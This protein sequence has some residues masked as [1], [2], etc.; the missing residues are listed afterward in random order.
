MKKVFFKNFIFITLLFAVFTVKISAQ[1]VVD[2]IVAT[3]SDGVRTQVITY[4]DLMWQLALEP[5]V[6]INPPNSDDLNRALQTTVNQRLITLEAQRLPSIRANEKEIEAKIKDT[7]ERFTTQT[8][9]IERLK[10][11]GFE[12][13]TDENFRKIME[14]RVAIEK[15]LDFRFRSFVVVTPEDEMR[16][17]QE[18]YLPKFR[19]ENPG[20]LMPTLNQLR[21][22]INQILTET[23]IS[24]DID[25]FLENAKDRAEIV[26]LNNV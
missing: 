9:F 3:V 24:N 16:Y 15:Y 17:Y 8:E 25:K 6:S 14:Q 23:K 18:I 5:D 10:K 26:Y 13:A 21:P 12:S 22:Q 2:K 1:E 4:S 19:K 20:M 7:L 11:V